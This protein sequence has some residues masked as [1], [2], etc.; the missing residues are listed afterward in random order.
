[1][2]KKIAFIIAAVLLLL[3]TAYAASAVQSKLMIPPFT[4]TSTPNTAAT[5]NEL[6]SYQVTITFNPS[7][8]PLNYALVSAPSGMT[9]SSTGL[10]TWTPTTAGT[11]LVNLSVSSASGTA[12]TEYQSYYILVTQATPTSMLEITKVRADVGGK[13]DSLTSEGTFDPNANLGDEISLRVTVAN[14]LPSGISANDI[15]SVDV[16]LSSDLTAADG[17][18]ETISKISAGSDKDVTFTFTLDP[19]EVNPADAPFDIDIDVEGRTTSGVTYTDHWTVTLDM[20]RKSRE[21]YVIEATATPTTLT[22]GGSNKVRVD[23]D[24]RNI[25][26]NDITD[27]MIRYRMTDLGL[28]DVTKGI[29]LMEGDSQSYSHSVIIPAGIT[30]D[31]YLL[32]VDT[33]TS[34]STSTISSMMAFNIVVPSC[35]TNN[36]SNNGGDNTSTIVINPPV[37]IIV[38]GT[39]VSTTSGQSGLFDSNNALYLVLIGALAVL[40]LVMIVF[41]VVRMRK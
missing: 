4:I 34:Q 41:F 37:G 40:V 27:G 21:F 16:T 31:T 26:T 23:L 24:L 5:T 22:C 12:Y 15:K 28:D 32:E 19:N 30:P 3:I 33:Y 38:S 2:N 6:Y 18:D 25:G 7:V 10:V 1:M 17:L 14:N 36:N 29:S 13:S 39:P 20:D 9:I 8:V 35:T 11:Y